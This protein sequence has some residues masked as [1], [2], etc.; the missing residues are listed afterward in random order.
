MTLT[1]PHC[2]ARFRV[3]PGVTFDA[4]QTRVPCP[5][6]GRPVPCRRRPYPGS[7]RRSDQWKQ[8]FYGERK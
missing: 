3:D 5:D 8:M 4:N 7:S 1:C 2:R 6:C